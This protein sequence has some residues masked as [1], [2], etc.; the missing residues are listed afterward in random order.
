MDHIIEH[1]ILKKDA[2]SYWINKCKLSVYPD[3]FYYNIYNIEC[4]F[5]PDKFTIVIDNNMIFDDMGMFHSR[6]IRNS[7]IYKNTQQIIYI[8]R[9]CNLSI[10]YRS[11]ELFCNIEYNREFNGIKDS[12]IFYYQTGIVLCKYDK[13]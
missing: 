6:E 12:A 7:D 10:Y 3:A 1:F 9:E 2:F 5:T 8:I 13:K 4:T 11:G